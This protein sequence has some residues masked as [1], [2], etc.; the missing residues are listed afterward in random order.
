MMSTVD[1]K[2]LTQQW[3]D[4]LVMAFVKLHTGVELNGVEMGGGG[5]GAKERPAEDSPRDVRTLKTKGE[6][7]R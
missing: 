1:T 3:S 5:G 4:L 6:D 7:D 2:I